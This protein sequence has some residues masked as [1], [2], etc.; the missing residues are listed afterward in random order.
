MNTFYNTQ[1]VLSVLAIGGLIAF[2]KDLSN[3]I[4]HLYK[5][6]LTREGAAKIQVATVLMV[7]MCIV[8]LVI[9]L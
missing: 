4:A 1:L 5:V 8:I 2:A 3:A 7:G 9:W 6:A